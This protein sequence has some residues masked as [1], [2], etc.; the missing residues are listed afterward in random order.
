[1]DEKKVEFFIYLFAGILLGAS[2]GFV[3]TLSN[4]LGFTPLW[5]TGK[6]VLCIYFVSILGLAIIGLYFLKK[7]EGCEKEWRRKN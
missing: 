5:R 1:M 6:M 7:E 2:W 3:I 4:L